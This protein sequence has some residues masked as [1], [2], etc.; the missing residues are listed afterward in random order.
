MG[1]DHAIALI[2]VGRSKLDSVFVKGS[3]EREAI[4]GDAEDA[5]TLALCFVGA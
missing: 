2:Q 4:N 5:T 3:V 1:S